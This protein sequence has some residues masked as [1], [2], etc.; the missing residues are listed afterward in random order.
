MFITLETAS[1]Q[2]CGM[3]PTINT[4]CMCCSVP[5]LKLWPPC[6]RD[7]SVIQSA[8]YKSY[9][10]GSKSHLTFN[11]D[12]KWKQLKRCWNCPLNCRTFDAF[13]PKE[14]VLMFFTCL[15]YCQLEVCSDKIDVSVWRK[16]V[17]VAEFEFE[18]SLDVHNKV[19]IL[20]HKTPVEQTMLI[21]VQA[22]IVQFR[23]V[24]MTR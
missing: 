24:F 8:K 6:G 16:H 23:L 18:S 3:C 13:S 1:S 10:L 5:T 9:R 14:D 19:N 2:T 22:N 17:T 12:Y 20:G 11:L 7:K 4:L 21:Y 15:I